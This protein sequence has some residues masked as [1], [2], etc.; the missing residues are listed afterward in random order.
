MQ[1]VSVSVY[2]TRIKD[3]TR[4]NKKFTA[5]D[6]MCI[7]LIIY[8]DKRVIESKL[9]RTPFIMIIISSIVM[10]DQDWPEIATDKL[11]T[12]KNDSGDRSTR[13][14]LSFTDQISANGNKLSYL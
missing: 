7:K 11:V 6:S 9:C 13:P 3:I 10:T 1:H 8:R 4:I 5:T 2:V 12:L 14:P